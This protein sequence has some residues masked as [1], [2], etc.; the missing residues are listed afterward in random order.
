M[1]SLWNSLV[2]QRKQEM[3]NCWQDFHRILLWFLRQENGGVSVQPPPEDTGFWRVV[4]Q[5]IAGRFT[6]FWR[7]VKIMCPLNIFH[8]ILCTWGRVSLNVF[9]MPY[10]KLCCSKFT[11]F[12][13]IFVRFWKYIFFPKN[14]R[15]FDI[16]HREFLKKSDFLGH[17]FQLVFLVR[18]DPSV[19][20]NFHRVLLSLLAH[21]EFPHKDTTV[22]IRAY[23][24]NPV[25]EY[26]R[27]MVKPCSH[28]SCFLLNL[29]SCD[30]IP[31]HFSV[32]YIEIFF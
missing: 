28:F 1:Y 7:W 6:A 8:K 31:K 25:L 13:D 26:N 15:F 29:F 3:K 24:Q 14:K 2:T 27:S 19:T 10:L 30:W 17:F 5:K 16:L 21:Q 23:N 9:F 11:W 12:Y 4:K 22:Y 20:K 32:Y 18:P